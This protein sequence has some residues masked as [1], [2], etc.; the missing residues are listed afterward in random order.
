MFKR[1]ILAAAAACALRRGH[2]GTGK[3]DPGHALGREGHGPARRYGRRRLH[4]AGERTGASDS[5]PTTSRSSTSRAA[6]S[7]RRTDSAVRR[8]A[9]DLAAQRADDRRPAVRHRRHQPAADHAQDHLG[10]PRA[11]VVRDRAHRAGASDDRGGDLGRRLE[12][13]HPRGPGVAVIGQPG[14]DADRHHR[15]S[16]R[17]RHVHRHRR[18]AAEHRRERHRQRQ[19]LAIAAA[20]RRRRRCRSG[21]AGALIGGRQR[22]GVPDRREPDGDH[23][24]ERSAVPRHQR[25]PHRRQLRRLSRHRY[26]RVASLTAR[27]RWQAGALR[28]PAFLRNGAPFHVRRRAHVLRARLRIQRHTF[29]A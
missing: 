26:S 27:R 21:R 20:S 17:A 22:P 1:T 24:G 4:G 14:V 12:P 15:S 18:S 29:V 23:A 28:A 19:R 11:L 7:P 10:R 8:R 25:R 6:T 13:R 9:D 3:R 5:R 16:G 2:A